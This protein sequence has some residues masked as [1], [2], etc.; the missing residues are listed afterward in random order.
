MILKK[1]AS[2][3]LASFLVVGSVG[4]QANAA[5]YA[6]PAFSFA[7]TSPSLLQMTMM[8]GNP[9]T[10]GAQGCVLPLKGPAPAVQPATPV[11]QPAAP[12]VAQAAPAAVEEAGNGIGLWPILLGLA[13]VA[14]GVIAL[15]GDNDDD[16]PVSP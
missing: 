13:A 11:T 5:A 2:A 14:G 8:M 4:A 3:A 10:S 1:A 15:S 12:A 6:A 16:A 7:A 9:C